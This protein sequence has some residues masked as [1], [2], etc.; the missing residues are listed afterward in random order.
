MEEEL[1]YVL[2]LKEIFGK[3]QKNMIDRLK[4]RGLGVNY[5][6]N[7]MELPIISIS[8]CHYEIGIHEDCH[9]IA[10][11]FQGSRDNNQSRLEGFR[12]H[13]QALEHKLGYRIILGPHE[14]QH[15]K[16][17]WIKM[18]LKPLTLD[19]VDQYSELTTNL[20]V[21]TLPILQAIIN[22]EKNL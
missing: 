20:I 7:V 22:R 4:F 5:R 11:H 17:L 10:L 13:Q 1:S 21:L 12:P 16:R 14:G 19:L 8:G 15:R 2:F 6:E 9:E 3:I 18:P